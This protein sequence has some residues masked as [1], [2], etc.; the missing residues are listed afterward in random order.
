[1]NTMPLTLGR[2]P[3]VGAVIA[4]AALTLLAPVSLA[5]TPVSEV[6]TEG[7]AHPAQIHAGTCAELG[8]AAFSLMDVAIPTDAI[9]EGAATAHPVKLSQTHVEM[10]LQ[11]MIDG[12]YA[13]N[14]SL[15]ADEPDTSVAC[16]DIGGFVITDP[17]GRIEL[18]VGLG[19]VND[20]GHIGI[21]RLGVGDDANDTEVSV[22]LVE[23]DE[24]Q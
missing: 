20:S 14:V 18:F 21:V 1:M 24:M 17:A 7:E 11:E 13:I 22:Q 23:P 3:R 12:G 8:E 10:P 4:F 5:Q 2:S 16:A 9:R 19:E 15:S 6:D